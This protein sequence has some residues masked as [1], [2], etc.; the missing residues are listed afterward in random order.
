[1]G[2]A[3]GTGTAGAVSPF[4]DPSAETGA[5]A[6][7]AYR[8][9][10]RRQAAALL[11]LLPDGAVRSL[12]ARAREWAVSA[13]NHEEKDPMATLRRYCERIL[14]LPPFREWLADVEAN[15]DAHAAELDRHPPGAPG[16]AT[17]VT[18]DVRRLDHGGETWYAGLSVV[19]DGP[20]WRGFITFHRGP[21]SRSH[22]TAD[23]FREESAGDVRARFWS[24]DQA[25]LR[26]FLR[27]VLP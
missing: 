9:Y 23:V 20:A 21:E 4:P 10:R 16:P 13:G 3:S 19:P 17:P 5:E 6:R 24:F 11:R 18:V 12:Y 15:P 26:A 22:R 7:S 27:S 8:A 2:R 25:A 14:P 1:M